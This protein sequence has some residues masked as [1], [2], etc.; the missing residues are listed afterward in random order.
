MT[1]VTNS[2]STTN[3]TGYD[4]MGRVLGTSQVIGG[5]TYAMSY[6]Y[7]LAGGMTTQTYP[8]GRVVTTGYDTAGRVNGLSG[9]Q[10]KIYATTFLYAAH[11]GV[12]SMNLGNTLWEHSHFN[13]RLQ[14]DEIGLGTSNGDSSKLKLEYAYN[15]L[16]AGDNNGNV[17]SQKITFDTLGTQTVIQQGYLYDPLNRLLDANETGGWHQTYTYDRYG[18]RTTVDNHGGIYLPTFSLAVSEAN[19]RVTDPGFNYDAAGNLKQQPDTPGAAT[20]KL[21]TYDAENRLT[22]LNGS[23]GTYVYD[24]DGRRVKKM[25]D[26]S[27]TTYVYNAQGQ[28]VAEYTNTSPTGNGGTSYLTADHLGS[29]RVVTDSNANVIARHDYLPFGEEVGEPYGSRTNRMGYD[30]FDSTNQRFTGKERDSESGLDYFDTRYLASTMGRFVSPDDGTGYDSAQP[31]SLNR[32]SYVRNN[33]LRYVDPYGH[34]TH[35]AANGDVLAVYDDGDLGVYEHTDIDNRKDWDGSKLDADD[36]GTNRMG[37][38][39]RWG[40]FANWDKKHP[41]G[42]S[43]S[44]APGAFIHFGE[45]IDN[46]VNFMNV[47]AKEQGLTATAFDSMHN[48]ILDI[49]TGGLADHGV[50]TG[51]LLNGKYATI[52]S[53][54]NYLAGLNAMT[55]TLNGE[56][57]SPEFAQKLFGAYQAGGVLGFAYTLSTGKNYPGT[58]APYWGEVPYSGFMQQEGINAGSHK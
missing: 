41:L 29:T 49:K 7:N 22:K 51:Y 50:Y 56:H 11:G 5:Q 21:Y 8:S 27:I 35:T 20:Y 28:L 1:Q 24:G 43:G 25:V 39:K 32:Y 16:G 58:S 55:S 13:G 17:L 14:P 23:A 2:N 48:G 47:V 38:T 26:A 31:Q 33:P 57:I 54:G 42:I 34:S 15:T 53:A 9:P 52:R 4:A 19:N 37:E 3:Y 44:A 12:G 45:N 18:N 40:E 30:V 36:E 6:R 10:S 46:I